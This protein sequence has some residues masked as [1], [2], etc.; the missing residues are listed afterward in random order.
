MGRNKP[1]QN[2]AAGLPEFKQLRKYKGTK[3]KG[4][5]FV[6]RWGVWAS[7]ICSTVSLPACFNLE[8]SCHICIVALEDDTLHVHAA[9]SPLLQPL[10]DLPS[11]TMKRCCASY[12][13]LT[14]TCSPTP[15]TTCLPPLIQG[16]VATR[17]RS[18][19]Q[20]IPTFLFIH[21]PLSPSSSLL[22][23]S[24]SFII[25]SWTGSERPD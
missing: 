19:P 4:E 16:R 8:L 1:K 10:N 9:L 11:L 3:C 14:H 12:R 22:P 2:T 13:P 6:P 7:S 5:A 15:H 23:L 18:L 24:P 20:S 21:I 17:V 25:K